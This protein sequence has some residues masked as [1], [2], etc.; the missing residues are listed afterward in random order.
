M[1]VELFTSKERVPCIQKILG[2]K[3]VIVEEKD[4][5]KIQITLTSGID[6]LCLFHA[7]VDFGI[8]YAINSL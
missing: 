1:T 4:D 8:D 3:V 7:G 5:V 6:A 2:D